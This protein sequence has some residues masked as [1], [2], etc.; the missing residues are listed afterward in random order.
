M[1]GA[2]LVDKPLGVT[3]NFALQKVKRLLAAKK[4]GHAGTLDPLASGL[5]IALFGEATKFAGLL[6]DSDKEYLAT[7]KLGETTATGDAEGAILKSSPVEVS[8]AE[9]R[10]V[11]KRFHGEIEQVPPMH[12]A[13]KRD[14]VPLYKLARRG[15]SVERKPR[16]VRIL[17][18]EM[19]DFQKPLLEIRV[20]CSKGTYVRTLAEDIGAAL[21]CG[22]HLAGLR[23]TASGQFRVDDAIAVDVLEGM[24]PAERR[25][26]LLGLD[27][28]LAE[29]PR[30][31]LDAGLAAKLRNGQSLALQTSPEGISA[32]YGPGGA[33][34]GI[35]RAEEGILRPLR[36]TQVAEKG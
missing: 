29:L 23:R 26:R 24:A 16:R 10:E 3:S 11:L 35:G 32:V 31:D 6:L 19:L 33:L 25:A 22:A 28:L 21:G 34:I 27:A 18:L 12:S 2:L 30:I 36:L 13:L 5:L 20:R 15:E 1:D 9:L 14:G 4:A 17:E 8:A 7:L